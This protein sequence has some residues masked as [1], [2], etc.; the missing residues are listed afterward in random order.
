MSGVTV[1]ATVPVYHLKSCY[2]NIHGWTS[3]VI[4]NKLTNSDFLSNINECDLV[5]LSEIHCEKEVS[6]PGFISL[7]QKIRE[8]SHRGPKISG[9]IG[10][11]IK[12]KFRNL[13]QAIPNSNEDS[14]WVNIK[15][16]LCEEKEDI[17]VGSFYVSPERKNDI[18]TDFFTTLNDEINN[19]RK[20]GTVL[21]QGDLNARTGVEQDFVTFDKLDNSD[22]NCAE[23]L[24][25]RNSE[26]KTTNKRGKE[27]LDI[28]KVNELLITNGRKVGDLFG[29]FTSHQWNGSALNDYLLTPVPFLNR[30]ASFSVGD[31]VP[32]ISDHCPIYST[33]IL[34]NVKT[35]TPPR[36]KLL[37]VEPNFIFNAKAKSMFLGALN[38]NDSR[39]AFSKLVEDEDISPCEMGDLVKTMLVNTARKC[40]VKTRKHNSP[41]NLSAPWFDKECVIAKN[42]LGYLGNQ[43]KKDPGNIALRESLLHSKRSFKKHTA[44]KKRKYKQKITDEMNSS[45]KNQKQFWRLL[46]KLSDKKENTSAFLSH[47]SL[48]SHFKSLLNSAGSEEIPPECKEHGQ[49]DQPITEEELKTAS[50][51]CL[52]PGKGVGIDIVGNEML[53]CLLQVNPNVLLKLFNLVLSK[54]SVLPDWVVSY[55][56]P[57]YKDGPKSD[58]NNYRGISLL[59]CVGKLFLS[60]LHNRL[61]QFTVDNNVVSQTQLGFR[62]G[63]RTSDAHIVIRNLVDKYCHKNGKKIYSCFIDLSK[64][65]DTVPRDLLLNKLLDAGIKGKFFNIIRSIYSNDSACVKIDHMCTE[66]FSINQGVRQGCVLSPLLF[67]IF[68]ADLAK[69]L[70]S[71]DNNSLKLGEIGINSIFWADDIVL[72]AESE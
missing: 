7:K 23:D 62:K 18:K 4:G 2:W 22:S 39:K 9:G 31:Y 65:F 67:N 61:L 13:V 17:L 64:A 37:Q 1:T 56:V 66:R 70:S 12:E 20:K 55:I 3:K 25:S 43:L 48:L 19:F 6:I 30:I 47:N 36:N 71:L 38:T 14:I 16:D 41:G 33:I 58:P 52:K 35:T 5:C 15:K 51:N 50:E 8:K 21:V 63:N 28:C 42:E 45:H 26:D 34:K 68:M 44:F 49:L 24:Y 11:F 40:K 53:S 10:V 29:K 32:W 46:D 57:I 54:N 60:I 72:L 59:S 69:K 27:L